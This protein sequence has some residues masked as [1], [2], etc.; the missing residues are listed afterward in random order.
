MNL[1]ATLFPIVARAFKAGNIRLTRTEGRV[2]VYIKIEEDFGVIETTLD[3]G[4]ALKRVQEVRA[5]IS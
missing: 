3:I 1:A 4:K 2:G 5:A